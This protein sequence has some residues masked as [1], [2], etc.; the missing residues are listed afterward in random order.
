M[1]QKTILIFKGKY[2]AKLEF[3]KGKGGFIYSLRGSV[4]IF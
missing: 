1:V 3:F 2:K 4:D